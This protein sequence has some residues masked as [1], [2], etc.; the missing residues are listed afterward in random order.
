MK[1]TMTFLL[2]ILLL[3]TS[4]MAGNKEEPKQDTYE[5]LTGKDLKFG[6]AKNKD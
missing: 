6:K 4:A 5:C 3:S 1:P 2:T